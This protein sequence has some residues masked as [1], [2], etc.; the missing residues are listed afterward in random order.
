MSRRGGARSG[1]RAWNSNNGQR[2]NNG[3]F[4]DG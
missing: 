2:Y 1:G 4:N 3:K